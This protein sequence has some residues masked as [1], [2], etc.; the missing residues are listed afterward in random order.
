MGILQY[1]IYK[2]LLQLGVLGLQANV[3]YDVIQT[4]PMAM[5]DP[6]VNA[7]AFDVDCGLLPEAQQDSNLGHTDFCN[8][9]ILTGESTLQS[10]RIRPPCKSIVLR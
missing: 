5:N 4:N 9:S 3:V 7:S 8:W 2:K 1:P 10:V 6:L